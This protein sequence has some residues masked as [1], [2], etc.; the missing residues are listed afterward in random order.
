MIF[1]DRN[2]VKDLSSFPFIWL[3]ETYSVL[4]SEVMTTKTIEILKCGF[5]KEVIY[6]GCTSS[7]LSIFVI[8]FGWVPDLVGAT[9][10]P[11]KSDDRYAQLTRG[12]FII[13][14]FLQNPHFNS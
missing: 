13:N 11:P 12:A 6:Y 4:N 3:W 9:A 14:E 10:N 5:H 2:E 8:T 7:Q 1:D